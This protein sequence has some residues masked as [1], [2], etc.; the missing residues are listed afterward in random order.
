[1][2]HTLMNNMIPQ[3]D[4]RE[5]MLETGASRAIHEHDQLRQRLQ[6]LYRLACDVRHENDDAI[7][8][9][10]LQQLYA[11]VQALKS[12][13]NEH[14]R[15]EKHELFPYASWYLGLEPDLH[16]SIEQEYGLAGKYLHLFSVQAD[17]LQK[18]Y[19]RSEATRLASY[20]LYAYAALVNRL[21][22]ED[23]IIRS[24]DD[25]SNKYDF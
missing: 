5:L 3:P 10:K 13:W 9:D 18:P 15:W 14:D 24:L 25:R 20:I 11:E 6:R 4:M 1:M 22:E 23:Q 17:R 19:S 2:N 21:E 8:N 7:L 12:E 16:H